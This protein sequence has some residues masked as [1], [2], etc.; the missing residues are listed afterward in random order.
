MFLSMS[1]STVVSCLIYL[2]LFRKMEYRIVGYQKWRT[3]ARGVRLECS[4]RSDKTFLMLILESNKHLVCN[5]SRTLAERVVKS[6]KYLSQQ[7]ETDVDPE[8]TSWTQS[9][10]C[11]LPS[12][13]F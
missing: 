2:R 7:A 6:R 9:I 12:D 10:L 4:R 3:L 1:T 5:G 13:D 8:T 11:L